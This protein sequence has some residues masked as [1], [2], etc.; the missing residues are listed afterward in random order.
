MRNFIGQRIS[1]LKSQLGDPETVDQAR[2]EAKLEAYQEMTSKL[3][4]EF[5]EDIKFF[6]TIFEDRMIKAIQREKKST[7]SLFEM[8]QF[9]LAIGMNIED[10]KRLLRDNT[11]NTYKSLHYKGKKVHA[12]FI[13]EKPC[14][15]ELTPY[16]STVDIG[17]GAGE[18]IQ[19]RF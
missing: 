18:N 16:D 11:I 9:L 17:N 12:T 15:V 6:A 10:L 2:V 7:A 13:S 1:Q 4:D 14:V 5:I 19:K 3:N 8:F